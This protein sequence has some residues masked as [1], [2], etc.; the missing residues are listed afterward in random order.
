MEA[1][2]SL[3]PGKPTDK[4]E[5]KHAITEMNLVHYYWHFGGMSVLNYMAP[6]PR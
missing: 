1:N 3:Q 5:G 4:E 6:D 2:S